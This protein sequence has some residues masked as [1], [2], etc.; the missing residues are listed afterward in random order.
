MVLPLPS[1]GRVPGLRRA[2]AA[3]AAQAGRGAILERN[4]PP[5]PGPLLPR[6]EERERTNRVLGQC[7]D[8][9]LQT[10]LSAEI[11]GSRDARTAGSRLPSTPTMTE[12]INPWITSP[13]VTRKRKTSSLKL[14]KLIVPM[15]PNQ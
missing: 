7:Q 6:R 5:L 11:T 4:G 3:S 14:S 1:K 9:P 2:E 12:K 10:A 15:V 8:A 13:G